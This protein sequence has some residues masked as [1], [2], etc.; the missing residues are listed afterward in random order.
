[1]KTTV[2]CFGFFGAFALGI[3]MLTTGTAGAYLVDCPAALAQFPATETRCNLFSGLVIGGGLMGLV[4]GAVF[5]WV[6]AFGKW[7]E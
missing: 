4:G 6:I 5:S 3:V 1:M 2:I 7:Q